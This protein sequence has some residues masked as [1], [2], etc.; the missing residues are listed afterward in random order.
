MYNHHHENDSVDVALFQKK[1]L[2][3]GIVV[4]V[5]GFIL[6][7]WG[8]MQR[9]NANIALGKEAAT[10][11]M[12]TV[13]V[14]A[15]GLAEG[16]ATLVLPGNLEPLNSAAIY[17]QTNGYIKEWL[18]DIG[19]GVEKGQLLAILDAPELLHQLAQAKADYATALAEQQNAQ[20]MAERSNSLMARNSGAISREEVEQ[21]VNDAEAKTAATRAASANVQRLEALQGFTQL[22]APFAGVVTSR[23]A[24]LGDL[25]VAGNA[26]TRPLF[27]VSDTQRMR[28]YVRVPQSYAAQMQVGQLAHLIV[29]GYAERTF[30]A[31]V[32]RS[33]RAVDRESG[34]LL[35]E[36]QAENPQGI[37]LPGAYAQVSFTLST[38]QS[39]KVP[40]SAILY[41]DET[42]SVATIDSN[43]LVT[44]KPVQIGRDE[45]NRVEIVAGITVDD[46][47]IVTPPDA[48]RNGDEVII[49]TSH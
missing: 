47:V 46:R 48:I 4:C 45:G 49:A 24:Q 43:N 22:T 13:A 44:L 30:T 41:R 8:I 28:V 23:S 10:M 36:L 29:P 14:V 26:A 32:S 7:G 21:R 3:I 25:V 9:S 31:Q 19:D 5:A 42:P 20:S 39:I 38:A 15:P 40:G 1:L 16:P 17:A 18:V 27:T 35:V 37:L 6:A 34:S 11:A 2:K 33:A 12:P